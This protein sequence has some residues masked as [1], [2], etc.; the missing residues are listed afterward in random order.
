[1]NKVDFILGGATRC[2]TKKLHMIMQ[3][4]PN[5]VINQ[6]KNHPHFKKYT[7]ELHDTDNGLYFDASKQQTLDPWDIRTIHGRWDDDAKKCAEQYPDA[8]VIFTLRNPVTRAHSQFWKS[9]RDGKEKAHSFEDAID[10]EITG[11]RDIQTTGRCWIYKSQYQIHLDEW[12]ARFAPENIKI[13]IMEEWIDDPRKGLIELEQFLGLTKFSLNDSYEERI[14]RAFGLWRFLMPIKKQIKQMKRKPNPPMS[15]EIKA[16]LEEIFSV[17][18]M[19]VANIIGRKEIK[20]WK[21]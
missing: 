21:A 18:K 14:D 5:I 12:F 9:V 7:L 8:K 20:A 17:D 19:Y 11:K 10:E 2:G 16:Q 3:S 6:N 1:M 15:E 4:H 13:I